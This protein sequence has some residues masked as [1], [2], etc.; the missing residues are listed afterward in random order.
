MAEIIIDAEN[1]SLG[2]IATK[3]AAVLRAKHIPTFSPNAVSISQVK[4]I[5]FSKIKTIGKKMEQKAYVRY[6]GYPGGLK[7]ITAKKIMGKNPGLILEHAVSGM[8]P[9]NKLKKKFLKNLIIE[10]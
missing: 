1:K 4:V 2:R 5:N 9:K 7:K 10:D 3:V 6:S 8:L